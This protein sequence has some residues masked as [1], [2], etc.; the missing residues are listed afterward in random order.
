MQLY[1][2]EALCSRAAPL[3]LSSSDSD[4]PEPGFTVF[5][6]VTFTF[7]A[8]GEMDLQDVER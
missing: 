2:E 3:R 1:T 6:I 5:I 7:W 8:P 4:V